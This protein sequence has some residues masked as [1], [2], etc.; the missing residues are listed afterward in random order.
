MSSPESFVSLTGLMKLLQAQK[1]E[2]T[3]FDPEYKNLCLKLYKTTFFGRKYR[4]IAEI[5]VISQ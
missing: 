3:K 4:L 1:N 5:S 2:G